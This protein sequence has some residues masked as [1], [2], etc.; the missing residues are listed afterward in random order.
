[1]ILDKYHYIE[2][3]SKIISNPEKFEEIQEDILRVSWLSED[4]INNFLLKLKNL[5]HIPVKLYKQLHVSGSGPGILYGLPK[6]HKSEFLENK[7][8]RPIFAAY[9][10]ASYNISKFLVEIL[11]PLT[12]NHYTLKNSAQFRQQLEEIQGS[13]GLTMA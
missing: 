10:C 8:Y 1:M 5:K 6:I 3:V 9:N 11:S 7:L 12:K 4:R 13:D 2:G